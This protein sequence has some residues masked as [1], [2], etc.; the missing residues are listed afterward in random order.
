MPII[1]IEAATAAAL[2]FVSVMF[3]IVTYRLARAE[4][5]EKVLLQRLSRCGCDVASTSV[6]LP[7]T[8]ATRVPP[9]KVLVGLFRRVRP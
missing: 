5:R 1:S 8:V 3:S 7:E 6:P 2:V 9:G 4:Q